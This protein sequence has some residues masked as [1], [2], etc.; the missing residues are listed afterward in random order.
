MKNKTSAAGKGESENSKKCG[1]KVD[2][3]TSGKTAWRCENCG[4]IHYDDEAPEECPF[5]L[6]PNKPFKKV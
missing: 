1:I 5:C 3:S 6:F 2:M 4:E